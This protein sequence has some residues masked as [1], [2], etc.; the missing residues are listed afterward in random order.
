MF[1]GVTIH[2][3]HTEKEACPEVSKSCNLSIT[4]SRKNKFEVSF[5]S[6]TPCNSSPLTVKSPMQKP[7]S[8][9]TGAKLS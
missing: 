4:V 5:T 9:S 2:G 1:E 7:F 6:H 3:A 8:S